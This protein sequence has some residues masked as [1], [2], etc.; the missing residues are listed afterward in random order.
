MILTVIMA[1]A[2][3]LQQLSLSVYATAATA[4]RLTLGQGKERQFDQTIH[5][6][7][8]KSQF[9]GPFNEAG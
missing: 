6:L 2:V 9:A 1:T 4:A 8:F 5:P 7:M 3:R